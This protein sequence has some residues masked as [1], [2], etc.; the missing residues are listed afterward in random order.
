MGA[1]TL[2]TLWQRALQAWA[3][4]QRYRLLRGAQVLP[5]TATHQTAAG[6][7][8]ILSSQ[9]CLTLHIEDDEG[10]GSEVRWL[11]PGTKRQLRSH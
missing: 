1:T 9:R 3:R 2:H 5:M 11:R 7:V 6:T 4:K 10:Q 8:G